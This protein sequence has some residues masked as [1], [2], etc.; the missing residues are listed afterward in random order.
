MQKYLEEQD[1]SLSSGFAAEMGSIPL[2]PCGISDLF[3]SVRSE[4][5]ISP[6]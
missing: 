4:L 2:S 5:P 3:S 1:L 6:F